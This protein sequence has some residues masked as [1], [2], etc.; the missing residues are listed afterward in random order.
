MKLAGI[1]SLTSLV[2]IDP[3]PGA[4]QD[5]DGFETSE[6]KSSNQ[7][8]VTHLGSPAPDWLTSADVYNGWYSAWS[9]EVL[10]TRLKGFP[11]IVGVPHSAR[12]IERAHQSQVRVIHYISFYKAL[13]ISEA[14]KAAWPD[15]QGFLTSPLFRELDLGK[16]PEWALYTKEGA[17]RRPFD[18]SDYPGGWEQVCTASPGFEE[19]ALRGVRNLLELGADGLF[20]DNVHPTSHCYGPAF[21][22]HTHVNSMDNGEA[23]RKLIADVYALVKKISAK[24]I[25]ALNPGHVNPIYWP[26]C[27]AMMYESYVCSGATY[28]C[29]HSWDP[30]L[31]K[32]RACQQALQSGKAVLTLSYMGAPSYDVGNP[33]SHDTSGQPPSKED[34][35]YCYACSRISG[36]L[37]AD[38]FTLPPNHPGQVLYKIRVGPPLGALEQIEGI[39]L[40]RFRRGIVIVNPSEERKQI[41]ITRIQTSELRDIFAGEIVDVNGGSL[42]VEIAGQSGRVLASS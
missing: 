42:S 5:E 14:K 28:T 13:N 38:W 37:W 6:R 1:G 2:R 29:S 17:V 23:F 16:H 21:G 4:P 41:R 22:K 18:K 20:I 11:L 33:S 3:M 9:E 15:P 30:I 27:D 34:A 35:F 25:V 10:R 12:W 32:A 24:K 36:F 26:S 40:R 19:A 31:Q 8:E 39:Y 7:Q